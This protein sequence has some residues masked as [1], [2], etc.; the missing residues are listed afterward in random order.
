MA[1]KKST[2]KKTASKTKKHY[3]VVRSAELGSVSETAAV[4]VFDTARALSALNRRL[5]RFARVYPVKI[6]MD[7]ASPGTVEVYVLRDDWAIHQGVKMAY[8]QYLDNTEDERK[9]LSGSQVAR[10]EDFRIA[11]GVGATHNE[12]LAKLHDPTFTGTGTLM[13]AGEFE[14]STV[15]DSSDVRRTFTFGTPGAT[16][17]GILQEYDKKANAITSPTEATG[18][19]GDRTP[20]SEIN[21]EVNDLTALDM[22]QHG[23]NPPYDRTGVN[24]TT[25]W[26]KVATLGSGAAGDQQLSTGFINAPCGLVVLV[27][28]ANDWNSDQM[29]FEVQ[30]GKYKG[31]G[32]MSLLE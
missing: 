22:Q 21:S 7:P 26:V 32:G 1:S 8:D 27:G 5:Y 30:S 20:Y 17:Y 31:V 18:T 24:A 16:E 15:V 3:P 28:N 2:L 4:R 23:D 10:W 6:N 25:P 11:D 13:S 9:A 12:L 19:S 29:R 14:L